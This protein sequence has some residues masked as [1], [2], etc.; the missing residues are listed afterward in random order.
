[1]KKILFLAAGVLLFAVIRAGRQRHLESDRE[2]KWG[3]A[4]ARP[5]HDEVAA[6]AYFIGLEHNRRGE[7]ADPTR[8]WAEAESQLLATEAAVAV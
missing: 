1:M 7:P 2:E 4:P 6:R 5:A 8:D 3:P